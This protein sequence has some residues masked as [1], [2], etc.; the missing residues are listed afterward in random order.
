[1]RQSNSPRGTGNFTRKKVG[2][3]LVFGAVTALVA[4]LGS[5]AT[6]ASVD[7][8]WFETLTKPSLYP[9]GALFGIAWTVLYVLIAIAGWLGWRK[10]GGARVL[11]PWTIQIVLN[12]GWTVF[13]FGT[14]QPGWAMAVIVSLLIV[15][16]WTA[17]AMWRFDHIATYLFVPYILWIGFASYLNLAIITLN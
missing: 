4:F 15:A 3:L 10:G 14:R 13:F 16:I 9:P 6:A 2:S 5:M 12:L 1:M 17:V 8:E 11:I 7:S